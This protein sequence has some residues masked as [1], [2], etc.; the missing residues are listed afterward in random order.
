[1]ALTLIGYGLLL[2]ALGFAAAWAGLDSPNAVLITGF[3]GGGLSL[4]AAIA[5]LAGYKR[6][7]WAILISIAMGVVLLNEMVRVWLAFA[8]EEAA[9]VAARLAVTLMFLCSIAMSIYLLHGER[10]PEFYGT[11]GSPRQRE[12][13]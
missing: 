5:A 4:L 6:R 7:L 10:P 13:T 12:A 9:P 1:M 2:V 11:S 8:G 3:A